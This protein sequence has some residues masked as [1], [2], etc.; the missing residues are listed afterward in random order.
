MQLKSRSGA[1]RHR[2]QGIRLDILLIPE[3][4][5][6][7]KA[8]HWAYEHDDS[9]WDYYTRYTAIEEVFGP[10]AAHDNVPLVPSS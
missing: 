8:T 3:N 5:F 10:S 7:S 2:H 4:V 9:F 1:D 6:S